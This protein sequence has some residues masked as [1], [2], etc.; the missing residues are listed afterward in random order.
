VVADTK[1]AKKRLSKIFPTQREG[2]DYIR[3]LQRDSDRSMLEAKREKTLSEWFKWLA[4]N[5]W[6]ET[7]D[8]K[9]IKGRVVRFEKYVEA[10]WGDS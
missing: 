1:G 2:K 4:D 6:P 10:G 8:S 7:L 5:D 9:T 3:S